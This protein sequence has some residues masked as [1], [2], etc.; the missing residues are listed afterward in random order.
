MYG[1]P[2]STRLFRGM[3]IPAMRAISFPLALPLLV[4]RVLADD[5]DRPV[6]ADDLA[7]LAHRLDRR[8][9]LQWIPFE[10]WFRRAGSG[11]RCGR[12][13]RSG[14]RKAR[15][16]TVAPGRDPVRSA[17]SRRGGLRAVL[18]PRREDAR[19]VRRDG[20]RELEVGGQRA[21][22]RVDRPVVLGHPDGVPAG[23]DHR[24]DRED[25]ALL[26]KDPRVGPP[27][28][29]DL[30][31]LVH[32]AADA[33]ADERAHDRE[34]L[35]LDDGLDRMRDVAEAVPRADPLDGGVQRGL[36]R[37]E[38]LAR[39]RGDRPDGEGAG[40]VG[41]PAVEDHADV[42]GEDVPAAE[43]VLT[44]DT[45]DDHR[46]GRGADRAGEALVAL[47]R[48]LAALRADEL[49]RRLV[50]LFGGN[51][52]ADLRLE[53]RHGADE[54]VARGGHLVDLFRSLLD[55]Q[56]DSSSRSVA[57]VALMWSCTSVGGR[58]PSKRRRRFRSS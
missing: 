39:E 4:A 23:G 20:H 31:V 58:E 56:K 47:E 17:R 1:R 37:R 14:T 13:Y 11:G 34:P 2:I 19:A 46:V 51:A 25:H 49:L 52:G 36:G 33:V 18:V 50:E 7:L 30:G 5:Q 29:R 54:D 22:L 16:R 42:D 9:Y 55:D 28:V 43:L 38:Q 24:L 10:L 27:V 8:S 15:P 40:G 3:L 57:M 44:R 45:V 35:G 12:R 53:Q 41:D 26:E 48:R 6:A 21:V 32:R